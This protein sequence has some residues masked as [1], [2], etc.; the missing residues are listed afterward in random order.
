MGLVKGEG[1]CDSTWKGVSARIGND[2][3][4][5]LKHKPRDVSGGAVGETPSSQCRGRDL[6]LVRE[7]DPTRCS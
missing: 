5:G 4:C 2:E 3:A 6:S 7:L 1:G